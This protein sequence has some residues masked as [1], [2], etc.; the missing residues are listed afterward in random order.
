MSS[1]RIVRRSAQVIAAAAAAA[2]IL[3]ATASAEPAPAPTP[4]TLTHAFETLAATPNPDKASLQAAN[5]L[6]HLGTADAAGVLDGYQAGVSALQ[7]IGIQPFLYPT[8][9]PFCASNGGSPLGLAPAVAGAVPGPWPNLNI[10]LVDPKVVNS[11]QTLFAFVPMGLDADGADTSGMQVAWFNVNTLQ[12]GFVPMGTV[13][14]AAANAVPASV[15]D[16]LKPVVQGAIDQFFT[17]AIPMGGVRAV[18]VQTGKGTVLAAVFGTV[19]NG[20]K[21]CFFFPT[22]GVNNVN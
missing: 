2:C 22:V 10:P 9:S 12:G 20:G 16:V 7:S 11:G 17:A 21:S 3:P 8:A 1:S 14:Q 18:P 19:A 15:P 5:T 6:V 4:S 13:S